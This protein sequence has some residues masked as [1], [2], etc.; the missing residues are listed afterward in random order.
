[1]KKSMFSMHNTVD[2]KYSIG[3]DEAHSTD[4]TG[5]VDVV[6]RVNV[7]SNPSVGP[8]NVIGVLPNGADVVID[9]EENGFYHVRSGKLIGYCDKRYVNLTQ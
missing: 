6:V 9:G 5:K 2:D 4:R 8:D 3:V 7:R 1:M